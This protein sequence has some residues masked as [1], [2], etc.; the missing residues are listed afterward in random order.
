ME[1]L[2]RAIAAHGGREAWHGRAGFEQELDGGG[3]LWP[4]R[5]RR[6]PGRVRASFRTERPWTELSDYPRP[7]LRGVFDGSGVRIEDA[8]GVVVAE[9]T[10]ARAA[11]G[12]L[13]QHVRWDDLDALYFA[14]YA[15]WNYIAIPFLFE[16][17]DFV[18]TEEPGRVLAVRFPDGFPTHSPEQRFH[19]SDDGL[20][21]RHDYTAL[22]VGRY[23]KAAHVCS[24][25]REYDGLVAPS[26]RR[27]HPRR[28]N[29]KAAPAPTI[30]SLDIRSISARASA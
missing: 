27:V 29:G 14:G 8:G 25:H 7:G 11:F 24:E 16:R 4:L 5:L 6:A 28:R 18:V 22:V 2:E 1:L 17:P 12:R 30:V 15:L 20:L 3:A 26:R 13:R 9:R 21:V 23:A 19:F 10:E